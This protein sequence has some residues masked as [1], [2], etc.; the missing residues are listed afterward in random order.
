MWVSSLSSQNPKCPNC[1]P[2]MNLER[3][4]LR[5]D[6]FS[7]S[8]LSKNSK[9]TK[10]GDKT[11]EQTL[12]REKMQLQLSLKYEISRLSIVQPVQEL[13]FVFPSLFNCTVKEHKMKMWNT[14]WQYCSQRKNN[15]RGYSYIMKHFFTLQ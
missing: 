12:T 6:A 13:L 4:Q 8:V 10:F 7:V 1:H 3:F 15:V 5:G 14:A 9:N 2:F 11:N